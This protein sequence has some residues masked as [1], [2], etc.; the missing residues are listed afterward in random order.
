MRSLMDLRKRVPGFWGRCPP[1]RSLSVGGMLFPGPVELDISPL[2]V[3]PL[4]IQRKESMILIRSSPKEM[5]E[6]P[7]PLFS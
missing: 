7:Y 3:C 6:N 5:K 2:I 1:L 4:M